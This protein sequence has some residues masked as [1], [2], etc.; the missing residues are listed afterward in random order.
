MIPEQTP[1]SA[2]KSNIL[3]NVLKNSTAI[4]L[5]K[6]SL[7]QQKR[8]LEKSQNA[9]FCTKA[10]PSSKKTGWGTKMW[11]ITCVN[12]DRIDGMLPCRFTLIWK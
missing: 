8:N 10:K 5:M 9:V 11:K 7:L 12:C 4:L 2:M 1:A 3:L 6:I